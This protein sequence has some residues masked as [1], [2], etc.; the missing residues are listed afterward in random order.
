MAVFDGLPDVFTDALGESVTLTTSFGET[1]TVTG[2]IA[3]R[4]AEI[5][6]LAEVPIANRD[7]VIHLRDADLPQKPIGST[8]LFASGLRFKVTAVE[9]DG[10]GMTA[11]VL[12]RIK[13]WKQ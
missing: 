5:D 11:L 8:V 7:T 6:G 12:Q 2:I 1:S 13:L 9:P 4:F 10:K 3:R